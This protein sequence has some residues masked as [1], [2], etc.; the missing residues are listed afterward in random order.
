MFLAMLF[1]GCNIL[2]VTAFFEHAVLGV[3]NGLSCTRVGRVAWSHSGVRGQLSRPRT[4]M[5][6]AL[7][8]SS[9]AKDVIDSFGADLRG[10]VALVTG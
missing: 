3:A 2:P 9:T 10:K 5:S 4:M 6:S 1:A 8:K 7:G